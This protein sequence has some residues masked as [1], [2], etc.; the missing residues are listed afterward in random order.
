MSNIN[1]RATLVAGTASAAAGTGVTYAAGGEHMVA[2][3]LTL[4]QWSTAATIL[5]AV[6]TTAYTLYKFVVDLLDRRATRRK[7]DE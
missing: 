7:R 6:V 1:H 5:C 3:G 2:L 4:A